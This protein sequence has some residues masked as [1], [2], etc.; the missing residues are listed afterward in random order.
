LRSAPTGARPIR[1]AGSTRRVQPCPR[2]S[3]LQR[4]W[5]RPGWTAP[6]P[7]ARG[8]LSRPPPPAPSPPAGHAPDLL[9]RGLG[10]GAL[11]PT[12]PTVDPFSNA[13]YATRAAE[14]RTAPARAP[15]GATGP[16]RGGPAWAQV[17][18]ESA[19]SGGPPPQ[20]LRA[21]VRR[22]LSPGIEV[23]FPPIGG[24]DYTWPIEP[25]NPLWAPQFWAPPRFLPRGRLPPARRASLRGSHPDYVAPRPP[26]TP[27]RW[28][29]GHRLQR[30]PQALAVRIPA[31][32]PIRAGL[33]HAVRGGSANGQGPFPQEGFP[34]GKRSRR[35][36]GGLPVATT[37][38]SLTVY[39]Q[40]PAAADG[41]TLQVFADP[42]AARGAPVLTPLA[43]LPA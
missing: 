12:F 41:R 30:L 22:C 24:A 6:A 33:V 39:A 13:A 10:G 5:R 3:P 28:R 2:L 23:R 34:G 16:Q 7:P 25:C 37:K 32:R 35:P 29:A 21:P 40:A 4:L 15:L 17:D 43:G 36:Y 9:T 20:V 27:P 31:S 38:Q 8:L 19:C 1:R 11:V 42:L 26:E 14:Q 18:N